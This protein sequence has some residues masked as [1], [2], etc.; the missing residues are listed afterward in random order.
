MWNIS[1]QRG[2]GSTDLQPPS[3]IAVMF[4][5]WRNAWRRRVIRCA[6]SEPTNAMHAIIYIYN[7][8][9]IYH[10]SY[11]NCNIII[12]YNLNNYLIILV[13]KHVCDI[14]HQVPMAS[15]LYIIS[16]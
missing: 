2:S 16:I 1:Q 8:L 6:D 14:Y 9:D 11:H 12:L 4:A 10:T 3:L 15:L 7:M 5:R 13:S